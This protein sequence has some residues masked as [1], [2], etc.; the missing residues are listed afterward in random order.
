MNQVFKYQ[1]LFIGDRDS[2]FDEIEESLL[3]L[4]NLVNVPRDFLH[5]SR[6]DD[7][8]IRGN[9][10][11]AVVVAIKDPNLNDDQIR[12]ID[13]QI[14]Q[15]NIILPIY[16]ESMTAE[17]PDGKIQSFN[18]IKYDDKNGLG[19]KMVANLIL[20]GFGLF[21]IT[22][23]LFISY[24][25]KD[26]RDV[27]V[28]LFHYF[29]ALN[30]DVFLD[31]HSIPRGV[32]FQ[33]N[34]FHRMMD[35]D[36]VILLDTKHFFESPYCKEEQEKALAKKIG[37]VRVKWPDSTNPNFMGLAD[38]FGLSDRNFET[39][40]ED[41][42][43][44]TLLTEDTLN[45]LH[46][47]IE[48][49]RVRSVASRQDALTTEFIDTARRRNIDAFQVFPNLVKIEKEGISKYVYSTIGIPKSSTFQSV[50]AFLKS[51]MPGSVD[52]IVAYDDIC[53]LRSWT[54]HLNWLSEHP[55]INILRKSDFES[56][57]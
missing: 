1:L 27:A 20:D 7:A 18:G 48:S 39:T 9:Q 40:V 38:T 25:Q 35:C 57:I 47:R 46:N 11:T 26:S 2:V 29:E 53:V 24:R 34:L 33:D 43:Q 42:T 19:S 54:N 32:D 37:I 31:S 50:E 23:K 28:Q 55:K 3:R 52:Y 10:P 16:F 6:N 14:N 12:I 15:A 8:Q 49:M 45:E 44:K 30:F 4:F 13:S 41:G 22:R 5:V 51:F 21:N 36:A 56:A 17:Y